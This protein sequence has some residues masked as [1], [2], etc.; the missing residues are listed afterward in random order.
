MTKYAYSNDNEPNTSGLSEPDLRALGTIQPAG[1]T[2]RSESS[3]LRCLDKS[4]EYFELSYFDPPKGLER[5]IL[6]LFE[7]RFIHDP[8]DDH[9]PG[10]LGQLVF[11]VRGGAQARFGDRIDRLERYPVL[12]SAFD[13]AAP[14]RAHGP[15]WN[16]GV[17]LSPLGWAALTRASS[18]DY[19]DR[20]LPAS[21]LIGEEVNRFSDSLVDR[22]GKEEITA[23]QACLEI[24]TWISERLHPVP[25]EHELLIY[26]VLEWLGS[27]LN[28][29]L[30]Q[31]FANQTYSRR[32]FERLVKRYFGF[33]PR[34][35]ARKFRAVRAANLLA[36]SK[37]TDEGEAELAEAFVD[38]PHMI[39]EI[40]RFCG[41]TPSR[42][43]GGEESMFIRLSHIQNL[44]RFK[45]YRAV[46]SGKKPDGPPLV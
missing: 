15:L 16:L 34:G 38:Q 12:C 21:E 8:S 11:A 26:R 42:L 27:S 25:V 18:F 22:R 3:Q 32:Q 23:E 10:V 33:A 30:E 29:S 36:Q 20:F 17:S 5:Y 41:Y 6:A 28:P 2:L 9:H 24:A 43:G 35:L 13:V 4:N 1:R 39:R 7:T 45:P 19:R 14:Y 40:R 44:D 31:L 37:L 46:G